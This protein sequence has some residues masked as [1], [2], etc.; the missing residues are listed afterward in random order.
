MAG[1]IFLVLV[2]LLLVGAYVGGAVAWELDMRRRERKC[3]ADWE[4]ADRELRDWE[5]AML[6]EMYEDRY[7]GPLV[8]QTLS[9]LPQAFMGTA[10]VGFGGGAAGRPWNDVPIPQT[11]R[12]LYP[13]VPGA[14]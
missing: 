14:D 8:A 12:I 13:E 9:T 2:I 5:Y 4:A 11:T 1:L 10:T 7:I 6:Y 3:E